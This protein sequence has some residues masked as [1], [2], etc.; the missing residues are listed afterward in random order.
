MKFKIH[1]VT[2]E[3]ELLNTIAV[4]SEEEN[5]NTQPTKHI[6]ASEIFDEIERAIKRT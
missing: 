5:W 2:D 3:G 1:V 4:D 6:I